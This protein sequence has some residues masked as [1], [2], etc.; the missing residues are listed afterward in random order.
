MS[1]V[2]EQGV[3]GDIPYYVRRLTVEDLQR[4][5][6]LQQ[7]VVKALPNQETLEPLSA[8][9]FLFIL[10]GNGLM[11]G[12]FNHDRLIAFRAL[13]IPIVDDQS[14]G[15]DIGLTDE[16]DLKR[17]LYQEISNVH[18]DF[19]GYGLQKKMATIIMNQIDTSK[20]DYVLA[21]VMPYNIP[22][23][24]DKF[25]QGMYI[26]ALKE[27][28]GRKLRYIFVKYLHKHLQLRDESVFISMGDIEGQQNLLHNGYVG[29][30]YKK[31]DDD[32]F[33]EYKKVSN[34]GLE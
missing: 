26:A 32:W 33:I 5:L 1:E 22:S 16:A 29:V 30:A 31:Q 10:K 14:L 25:H 4:I 17:I 34:E 28:Y 24:K 13:L 15:R 20:F 19:R 9:E 18:P 23:I 21:T 27:K 7:E 11:I 8:E 2:L 6:D 3:L 12:I